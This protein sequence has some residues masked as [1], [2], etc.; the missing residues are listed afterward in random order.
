MGIER[1]RVSGMLGFALRIALPMPLNNAAIMVM[2]ED[3]RMA[4][5]LVRVISAARGDVIFAAN[6]TEAHQRLQQFQFSAAVLAWQIGV[7]AVAT[8]LRMHGVP[9][10]IFGPPVVGVA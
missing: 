3:A 6:R 4:S 2:C 8:A 1:R 7:D 10:Y 5:D 9:F